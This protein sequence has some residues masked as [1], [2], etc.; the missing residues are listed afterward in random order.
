MDGAAQSAETIEWANRLQITTVVRWLP[1]A[2]LILTYRVSASDLE[3]DCPDAL[4]E[5]CD[6]LTWR[7]AQQVLGDD[8]AFLQSLVQSSDP[9]DLSLG[10]LLHYPTFLIPPHTVTYLSQG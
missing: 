6:S 2:N 1:D 3:G 10:L 7:T 5:S 8:V 4:V 9:L